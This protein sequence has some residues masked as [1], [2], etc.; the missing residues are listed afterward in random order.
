[1][2]FNARDSVVVGEPVLSC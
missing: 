1:M 2:K